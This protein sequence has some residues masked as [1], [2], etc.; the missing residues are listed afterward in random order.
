MGYRE[1]RKRSIDHID[2]DSR[3]E[4]YWR[5]SVS[6]LIPV[7]LLATILLIPVVIA[8]Y[9][10][11]TLY[12]E[13]RV[14]DAHQRGILITSETT[15]HNMTE[16]FW[17]AGVQSDWQLLFRTVADYQSASVDCDDTIFYDDGLIIRLNS[18]LLLIDNSGALIQFKRFEHCQNSEKI[19]MDV[20]IAN[21]VVAALGLCDGKGSVI[22]G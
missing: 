6:L 5:L 1:K 14:L 18:H 4:F 11:N 17:K 19:T 22:Y 16:V 15:I 7:C 10:P 3:V 2:D 20:A 21:D 13:C 8:Q 9:W 12:A